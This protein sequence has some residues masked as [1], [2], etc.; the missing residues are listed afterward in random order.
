[1]P[2]MTFD[3]TLRA[4]F[5]IEAESRAEAE[6]ELTK[7]LDCA[8]INAGVYSGDIPLVGEASLLT[9]PVMA[10]DFDHDV[11]SPCDD[12]ESLRGLCETLLA[13]VGDMH[14]GYDPEQISNAISDVAEQASRMGLVA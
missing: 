8:T 3:L 9:G 2:A 7:A 11:V 12:V 14:R 4:C 10:K 1:M 13:A 5:T 6:N